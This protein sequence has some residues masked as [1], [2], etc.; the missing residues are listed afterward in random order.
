MRIC[1]Y[2]AFFQ[3]PSKHRL[4]LFTAGLAFLLLTVAATAQQVT[5]S[6]TSMS[7]ANTPVG[8]TSAVK[9]ATLTNTGTVLLTITSITT[10][11]PFAQ[12]NT[13]GTTVKAGKNCTI[14]VTF[15]PTVA[16]EAT[17]VVTIT[18]NATNSPQT[19][20]LSG[21]G[22]TGVSV[23]PTKLTFPTT[24][25]GT[26]SAPLTSTLA[27][28]NLT[29]LT[30]T[31]ITITGAFAQTN[32][33][34]TSL[35]AT[36]KCTISVTYTPT[37]TGTQTGVVTITDSASNSPQNVSGICLA[38]GREHFAVDRDG[39]LQQRYNAEPYDHRDLGHIEFRRRDR[40]GGIG[41]RGC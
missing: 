14:S 24:T 4:N 11:G 2:L 31:S 39:I 10:T 32:T 7:F 28:N 19:I 9:K 40:E 41:D 26:T 34:G 13:C 15:S 8:T 5:L 38:V 6:T 3:A 27:N 36:S 18:D 1:N 20:T 37:A 22:I 29:A 16:G 17:G 23:T 33:C 30:I 21:D 25:I 12:T 35:P